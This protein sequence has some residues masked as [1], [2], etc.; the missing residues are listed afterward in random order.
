MATTLYCLPCERCGVICSAQFCVDC[1]AVDPRMTAGGRAVRAQ[2]K[3]MAAR[4]RRIENAEFLA[5][6]YRQY[7]RTSD[8]RRR[9]RSQREQAA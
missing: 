1:R 7:D 4:Q 2:Q 8:Q 6:V 5:W 9:A 3:Y